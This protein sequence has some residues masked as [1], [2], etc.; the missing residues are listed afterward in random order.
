MKKVE[1]WRADDGELF[2]KRAECERHE[3]LRVIYDA[4]DGEFGF[5]HNMVPRE[6]IAWILDRYDVQ[7]PPR[8]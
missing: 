8:D 1:V 4:F 2:E 5:L 6:V 7:F 3:K